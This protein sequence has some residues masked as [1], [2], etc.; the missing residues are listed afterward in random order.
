MTKV[1]ESHG[2]SGEDTIP[3]RDLLPAR[4]LCPHVAEEER[5][6]ERNRLRRKRERNGNTAEKSDRD[7]EEERSKR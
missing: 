4:S 6:G 1:G 2:G 7:R 3:D 5:E